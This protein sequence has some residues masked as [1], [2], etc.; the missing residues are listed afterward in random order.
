MTVCAVFHAAAANVRLVGAGVPSVRPPTAGLVADTVTA[1]LGVLSNATVNVAVPPASVV[2]PDAVPRSSPP[3]SSV[4]CTV[5]STAASVVG[6]AAVSPVP[7]TRCAS[8]TVSLSVSASFRA[9]AV[10]VCA[11]FHVVAVNV[12]AVGA[13]STASVALL[14]TRTVT[15]PLGGAFRRTVYGFVRSAWPGSSRR[16][17]AV[18]LTTRPGGI[19]RVVTDAEAGPSSAWVRVAITRTV[20]SVPGRRPVTVWDWAV[21]VTL[22]T[23]SSRVASQDWPPVR[24]CTL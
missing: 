19:V 2:L 5:T 16:D 11:V 14:V 10:T 15:A 20:Y 3:S 8:V 4:T 13:A 23:L 1:A 24:H 21:P 9:A 18:G 6:Y 17:S 12:S 7:L 22:V